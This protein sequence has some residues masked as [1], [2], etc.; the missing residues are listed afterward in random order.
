[1]CPYLLA[2]AGVCSKTARVQNVWYAALFKKSQGAL[3]LVI[4]FLPVTTIN[5]GMKK[6]S[7][8][9]TIF[10]FNAGVSYS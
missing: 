10:V 9:G 5:L 8:E 3:G 7:I 2:G 6:S 4:A 1:M